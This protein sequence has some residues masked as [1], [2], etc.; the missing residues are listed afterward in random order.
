M[1]LSFTPHLQSNAQILA[2]PSSLPAREPTALNVSSKLC[3]TLNICT[4][5]DPPTPPPHVPSLSPAQ[6][7]SK[8]EREGGRALARV[9][10]QLDSDE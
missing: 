8:A 4:A 7:A 5:P 1:S 6:L 10:R 9:P 3:F 2:A